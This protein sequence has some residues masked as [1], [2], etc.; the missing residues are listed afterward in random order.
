MTKYLKAEPDLVKW[1]CTLY[2]PDTL[3]TW[4]PDEFK[5]YPTVEEESVPE[6]GEVEE[7]TLSRY[8]TR[9]PTQVPTRRVPTRG[10]NQ[11]TDHE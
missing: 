2:S 9:V 11:P 7:E 1:I 5:T 4:I 3:L 10:T 8:P 6:D